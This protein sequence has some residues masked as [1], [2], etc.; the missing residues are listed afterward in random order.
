MAFN[1]KIKLDDG[2]VIQESGATLTLSGNTKYGQHPDFTEDTQV[3]DKKYVDDNITSGTTSASTYNLLSPAAIDLGGIDEGYVLT[4]KTSNEIIQDLLFPEI[5]GT[6]T[7]PSTSTSLS[8][9]GLFEI[10]CQLT[11]VVVTSNFDRGSIDPQG[12]SASEFRSGPPNGYSFTGDGMVGGTQPSTSLSFT[13]ETSP[14]VVTEGDNEWGSCTFYDTGVQ[15]KSNKDNDFDSPLLAGN[16]PEDT[17]CLVGAYPIFATT[18][19]IGTLTKQGLRNM[20]TANNVQYTLV[21]ESGGDKQKFQIPC[22]WLSSR[23]LQGVCQ[24]D[25]VSGSWKYPGDSA[26]ASLNLYTTGAT[27]QS[28]QSASI[29]YREYTHNTADRDAV[30]IRLVFA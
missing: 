18:S 17:A 5:C 13:A 2:H 26:S 15:P 24:Y 30:D 11:S 28:I 8:Q 7:A 1:T 23:E 21:K 10:G 19:S 27:T 3:V 20:S 4:G 12:C 9:T 16:T 25:T 29:N 22:A 6:L 14:Y